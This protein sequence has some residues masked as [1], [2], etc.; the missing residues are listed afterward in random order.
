MKIQHQI[1]NLFT[2]FLAVCLFTSCSKSLTPEQTQF[3][4]SLD[5]FHNAASSL[6]SR[7]DAAKEL[8]SLAGGLQNSSPSTMNMKGSE[9][10]QKTESLTSAVDG[11]PSAKEQALASLAKLSSDYAVLQNKNQVLPEIQQFFGNLTPSDQS[12]IESDSAV[13]VLQEE[14]KRL[15]AQISGR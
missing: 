14:S 12:W 6:S 11:I 1:Q 3:V 2:A 7:Y 10:I 9:F 8:R 13:K 4:S 15:L 5:S